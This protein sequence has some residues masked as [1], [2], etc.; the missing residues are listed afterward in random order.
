MPAQPSHVIDFR[1][2]LDRIPDAPGHRAVIG[3]EAV[4]PLDLLLVGIGDA[5]QR[6]RDVDSPDHE[7]LSIL[8]D[9]TDAP[10]DEIPSAC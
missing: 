10:T 7:D 9:L 8:L 6:I 5:A 2:D 1:A 3:V 4:D